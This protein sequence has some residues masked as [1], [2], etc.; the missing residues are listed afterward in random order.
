M[1]KRIST[2][3]VVAFI[4]AVVMVGG[5]FLMSRGGQPA[6]QGSADA[7]AEC[8]AQGADT[9][10]VGFHWEAATHRCRRTEYVPQLSVP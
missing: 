4:A 2:L 9:P 5:V 7:K 3:V 8:L 6:S 10:G 1:T